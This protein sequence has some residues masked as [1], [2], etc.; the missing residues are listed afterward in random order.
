MS[1]VM[2]KPIQWVCDQHRSELACAS[3]QSDQDPCCSLTNSITSRK[4]DSEQYLISYGSG[5]VCPNVYNFK[6]DTSSSFFLS[7]FFCIVSTICIIFSVDIFIYKTV[8]KLYCIIVYMG[9]YR[10]RNVMIT[11]PNII[12]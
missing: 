12:F 7:S 10:A 3:A 4:T 8:D 2:T 1:R 11:S 6:I 5:L 9:W